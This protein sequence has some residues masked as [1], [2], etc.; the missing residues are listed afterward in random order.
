MTERSL[1][2]LKRDLE[3]DF[4]I[5][6]YLE[7]RE[8]FPDADPHFAI[9]GHG[10]D[11][12]LGLDLE[13]F[14]ISSYDYHLI[15]PQIDCDLDNDAGCLSKEELVQVVDSICR[16]TLKAIS[17]RQKIVSKSAH[18]IAN[19]E[20]ISDALIDA[21]IASLLEWIAL[22]KIKIPPSFQ[23]LVKVRLRIFNSNYV[24]ERTNQQIKGLVAFLSLE[25]PDISIRA[26]A[27]RV[28]V[29]P[30]TISRWMNGELRGLIESRRENG[31]D[32]PNIPDAD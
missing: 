10:Y 6:D 29:E 26:L 23:V 31:A 2:E 5:D 18:A 27:R 14:G 28:G 7:L 11:H 30:S 24:Q 17:D 25:N 13:K 8:R 15:C 22:Y 21:I 1:E 32:M 12:L 4:K 3:E 9:F 19:G 16:Q 20:A